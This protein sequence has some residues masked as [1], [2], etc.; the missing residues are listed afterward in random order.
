MPGIPP[1]RRC[2]PSAPST[3]TYANP[4]RTS[5]SW[6]KPKSTSSSVPGAHVH[7]LDDHG[8]VELGGVGR[9]ADDDARLVGRRRGGPGGPPSVGAPRA[10][11]RVGGGRAR[12]EVLVLGVVVDRRE[13]RRHGVGGVS[14]GATGDRSAHGGDGHPRMVVPVVVGGGGGAGERRRRAQHPDARQGDQQAARRAR[15]RRR[16]EEVGGRNIGRAP[17]TIRSAPLTDQRSETVH[18]VPRRC[19]LPTYAGWKTA[20]VL[21]SGSLNHAE[22]PMPGVVTT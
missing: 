8:A 16:G 15:V 7:P 18:N 12:D 2:P 20:M 4:S 1:R 6:A 10:A 21:P 13:A 3:P 5:S 14:R 22:L 11:R 17:W 19:S 9:A